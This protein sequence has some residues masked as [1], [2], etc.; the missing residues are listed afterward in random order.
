M[1][2]TEREDSP[3]PDVSGAVGDDPAVGEKDAFAWEKYGKTSL[4]ARVVGVFLWLTVRK[5]LALFSYMPRVLYPWAL[6]DMLAPLVIFPARDFQGELVRLPHCD[7]RWFTKNREDAPRAILYLHGGGFI[8][9]GINTHRRLA[10]QI[11]ASAQASVLAVDYR[12]LPEY[13]VDESVKDCVLGYRW[14]LDRGYRP[15]QIAFAGDSAG[16]YLVFATVVRLQEEGLPLPAALVG[17]S[18]FADWTVRTKV[19]HPNERID[20]LLPRPVFYYLERKVEESQARATVRGVEP[21]KI[22]LFERS[23]EGF[24]PVLLH[25]SAHEVLLPD[26]E[27]LAESLTRAGVPVKA[28]LWRGQPHVFQAVDFLIPEARASIAQ[29]GRFIY[30]TTEAPC[31]TERGAEEDE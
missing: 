21:P 31:E 11:A 24:P 4:I 27:R 25:A 17:I 10:T 15:E 9:C 2:S 20:S 29:I 6:V 28:K 13:C 14:L 19:T 3:D 30:Q 7:G 12:K 16:G 23:L 8:A 1:G 22:D 5:V 18:P 26:A